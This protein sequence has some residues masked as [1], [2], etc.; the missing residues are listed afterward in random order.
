M[1]AAHQCSSHCSSKPQD[2]ESMLEK[3]HEGTIIKKVIG[4]VSGKGGVGK[5]LVSSMLAV[6]H[7][8]RRIQNGR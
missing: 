7:A 5:S 6:R 2:K 3:P 4:V 8:P 1:T